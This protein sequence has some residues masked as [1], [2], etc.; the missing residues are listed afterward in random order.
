MAIKTDINT[1]FNSVL[2]RS[3]HI[4]SGK[5]ICRQLTYIMDGE[6][7]RLFEEISQKKPILQQQFCIIAVGGYGRMELCPQSDIDILYLHSQLDEELLCTTIS[8]INTYLYDAK[9][10]VGHS[11]RNLAECRLYLDSLESFYAILDARLIAGSQQLYEQFVIQILKNLPQNLIRKYGDSKKNHLRQRLLSEKPFLVSEPNL[12][13]D[14]FCLRDMQTIYWLEKLNR[15]KDA[16]VFYPPFTRGEIHVFEVAYDFFL[17]IRTTIHAVENH[18]NDRLDITSQPAVAEYL[19]Y[20]ER[21]DINSIDTLM[22]ALYSQQKHSYFYISIYLDTKRIRNKKGTNLLKIGGV[23]L[24][25]VEKTLYPPRLGSFFSHPDTVHRDIMQVFQ[26]SQEKCLNLSATLMNEIRFASEFLKDDFKNSKIAIDIFLNILKNKNFAGRI[27]TNMHHCN[28][29]GKLI[30]EF[31]ACKYFSLFSYH[32]EYPVD[33]HTLYILRELDKLVDGNFDDPLIQKEFD[34]CDDVDILYLAILVHDA[35][36]VKEGDHCQYGAEMAHAIGE[37]MG[38]ADDKIDLFDFLVEKHIDMSELSAK[39]DISD[40]VLIENFADSMASEHRLRLLYIFTIIDTKSVGPGILTNWKKDILHNLYTNTMNYF[41]DK[42]P[43]TGINTE[44]KDLTNYLQNKERIP[45]NF[46]QEI[47]TFAESVQPDT[48]L[49]FYSPR[50]VLR[51]YVN[52]SRFKNKPDEF[53]EL[54]GEKEPAYVLYTI[55]TQ[56]YKYLL[57]DI[58]GTVS[59]LGLSVVG[60]RSFSVRNFSITQI[61]ITQQEGSGNIDD[62]RLSRLRE[63]LVNVVENGYSVEELINSSSASYLQ[64]EIPEGMVEEMVEINNSLHQEYSILEV[65]LPD[66]IGLLYR[67]LK[68]LLSFEIE[69]DFIRV[70]T[71]ADYAY[72]SFYIK[73]LQGKKIIDPQLIIQIQERVKLQVKPT[74]PEYSSIDL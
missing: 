12:K 35:G 48:Y 14:P 50:K 42:K 57:S 67:I 49:R 39:R 20:G 21:S 45:Q 52:Y 30:P 28:I 29:L 43:F 61:Q 58:S 44:V 24:Q 1:R 11:C 34:L 71:S 59:S 70:S 64:N 56:K 62:E 73:D 8:Y 4:P 53:L 65:R 26:L 6:I 41:H 63:S 55:Y 17:K 9:K 37:R 74:I 10:Q 46:L 7:Y 51:H 31:G 25:Q 72:D 40:P 38:L 23:T 54:E 3:K 33:E 36:K 13:T 16:I 27:L 18:K 22:N 47:L 19:G 2:A 5:F 69:L 66:S 15:S 68:A 60:L 32:H